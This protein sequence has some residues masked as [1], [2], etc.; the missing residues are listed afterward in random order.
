MDWSEPGV[1]WSETGVDRSETGVDWYKTGVDWSE[2]T[3]CV[4][5]YNRNDHA[6]DTYLP[7]EAFCKRLRL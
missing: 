7:S 6:G 4:R 1:D 2:S 5:V 3:Y